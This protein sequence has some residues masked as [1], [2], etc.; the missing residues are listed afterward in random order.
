VS[1]ED[2]LNVYYSV[3][4]AYHFTDQHQKALEYLH[5]ADEFQRKSNFDLARTLA[6]LATVHYE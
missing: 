6:S 5:R 3:A 2:R 1:H 4:Q